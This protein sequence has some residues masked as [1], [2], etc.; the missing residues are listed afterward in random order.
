MNETITIKPKR[1]DEIIDAKKGSLD[2]DELGILS[3]LIEQCEAVT[4]KIP[5]ADPITIIQV[6]MEE[7]ELF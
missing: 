4:V 5:E 7:R 3:Y 2:Y 6:I 1:N